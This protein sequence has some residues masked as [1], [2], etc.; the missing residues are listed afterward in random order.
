MKT[1][2]TIKYTPEQLKAIESIAE[3]DKTLS[4]L[5][6]GKALAKTELDRNKWSERID[7]MLEERLKL[8]RVRDGK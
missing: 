1:K 5:S 7:A 8:M 3:L 6:E 2:S 4:M